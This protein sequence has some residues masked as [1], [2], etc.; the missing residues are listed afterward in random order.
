MSNTSQPSNSVGN[1]RVVVQLSPSTLIPLEV[2]NK[3]VTFTDLLDQLQERLEIILPAKTD[4]SSI[5]KTYAEKEYQNIIQQSS[6]LDE[7]QVVLMVL[8]LK[9]SKK[10]FLTTMVKNSL[11]KKR[12]SENVSQS[13]QPSTVDSST[14]IG[15]TLEVTSSEEISPSSKT[16]KIKKKIVKLTDSVYSYSGSC[17][18]LRQLSDMVSASSS[19]LPS[20]DQVQ[21]SVATDLNEFLYIELHPT[22]ELSRVK[23][24]H[25]LLDVTCMNETLFNT[26]Y[27]L[28]QL[29]KNQIQ[30]MF[31]PN[32]SS[33]N[34]KA[35]IAIA[36]L[37]G[38]QLLTPIKVPYVLRVCFNYLRNN[39]GL[40]TQ[41][42]FREAGSRKRIQDL[43]KL[44]N[45]FMAYPH[46]FPS[47]S[48]EIPQGVGV[49]AVADLI[50]SYIRSLPDC[51]LTFEK[52][53]E[54]IELFKDVKKDEMD[55]EKTNELVEKVKLILLDLP[56]INRI[57]LSELL[58]LLYD[59]SCN[60]ENMEATKMTS[61]NM[62]IVI[63]PNLLFV[64]S[65]TDAG[66]I[67]MDDFK[68]LSIRTQMKRQHETISVVC[69][70]CQF[71][72]ENYKSLFCN[73]KPARVTS[74]T[75]PKDVYDMNE[76]LIKLNEKEQQIAFLKKETFKDLQ[77]EKIIKQLQAENVQLLR[78]NKLLTKAASD[79]V[80]EMDKPQQQVI[81][82]ESDS[83]SSGIGRFLLVM[84]FASLVLVLVFAHFS[85]H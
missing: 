71:L 61:K 7:Q 85:N 1:L 43:I 23:V 50:K 62:G 56:E 68:R 82:T 37:K 51:L 19:Y 40:K 53:E 21:E 81:S 72:I 18:N 24:F 73:T 59:I 31:A 70:I 4:D 60:N 66:R 6:L 32:I 20:L 27:Y 57:V 46:M 39:S 10:N 5:S 74:Q 80:K 15:S 13:R 44:F 38:E 77:K 41:G 78:E 83:S 75:L 3:Q 26:H 11:K 58:S 54:F 29:E 63:G 69:D 8:S 28:K 33:D 76:L 12:N 25:N 35:T 30:Q 42:I 17:V 2:S 9:Q 67:I 49:F 65:T 84:C 64:P 55:P 79:E 34:D 16:L 14:V 45:T 47:L 36:D 48:I 52:Y 22:L